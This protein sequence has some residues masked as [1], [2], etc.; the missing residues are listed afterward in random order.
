MLNNMDTFF[1]FHIKSISY[2]LILHSS[3]VI[4]IEVFLI[5]LEILINH[6]LQKLPLHIYQHL[7]SFFH[8]ILFSL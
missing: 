5:K 3:L 7:L 6:Y 2:H 1:K 4:N 8:L